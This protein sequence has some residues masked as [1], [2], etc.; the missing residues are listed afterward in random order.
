LAK[1]TIV[2]NFYAPTGTLAV[3]PYSGGTPRDLD[4]KIAFVD[5]SSSNEMAVVRQTDHGFQLEYPVG[6]VLYRTAGYISQPRISPSGDAVAFLD[7][8]EDNNSGVVALVDRKGTK[9]LLSPQYAAADGLA[10]EPHGK[11]VWF[12]AASEGAR[13]QLRAVTLEGKV[14]T[15]Y[16]QAMSIILF[17]ISRDGRV[18][19]ANSERRMKLIVH[20]A[21]EKGERDLSWLDWSSLESL[22]PDSKL[23]TFSETAEGA[24]SSKIIYIRETSGA[25]PVLLGEG[26]YPSLSPDGTS[27]VSSMPNTIEVYPT[28][29]GQPRVVTNSRSGWWCRQFL[30]PL[31]PR[32]QAARA[33]G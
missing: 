31:T 13:L 12:T 6:T 23:I 33:A 29:A 1:N 14:R 9:R 17:D 15:V 8:S 24:G 22:S 30:L 28:R 3:A 25:P 32:R 16:S 18:L 2:G 20:T 21:G 11:E 27:V 10:W 26:H 19:M 7:H 4:E 5:W